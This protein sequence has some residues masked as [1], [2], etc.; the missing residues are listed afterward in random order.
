M[1]TTSTL[2]QAPLLPVNHKADRPLRIVLTIMAFLAALALLGS[3]MTERAYAGWETELS[4]FATVQ[5]M[6]DTA[7][8]VM[9]ATQTARDAL[10]DFNVVPVDTVAARALIDPWLGGA[11]LPEGIVLPVLLRVETT[12]RVTLTAA[13]D[14]TGLR[15][16]IEDQ[17]RWQSELSRT[18]N[19]IG[20]VSGLLLLLIV[21]GSLATTIFA[22]Q[23]A[24]AAETGSV[25]V[26][27]QVGASERFIRG[28]FVRRA[29]RIGLVSATI[30]AIL[31]A[32]LA[33]VL[34]VMGGFG[35]SAFVP[36]VSIVLRDIIA[37]IVL[38]GVLTGLGALAA[39]AAVRQI[40]KS[41]RRA[42]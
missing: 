37:L 38:V 10:S 16:Q 25:S 39:G 26:F 24:I 41:G 17:S 36:E 4:G 33:L 3:R 29:L 27:T 19:R 20:W 21:S 2:R 35:D 23:S 14:T 18:R 15:Y 5:I 30:G 28:L 12:D 8:S 1:T 11:D 40:L 31:A 32:V 42:S 9:D 6:S 34:S 13:M 22:T 7:D